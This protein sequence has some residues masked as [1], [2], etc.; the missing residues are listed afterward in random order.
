[1]GIADI[2]AGPVSTLVTDL[3]DRVF[4]DKDKQAAER[5]AFLQKSQ[6]I[7]AQLATA[8]AAIDQAEAANTSVFVAG[9][10]PFIGWVCG[11]ALAYHFIFQPF[12]TYIL[13]NFTNVK[14]VLPEFD[15]SQL[16]TILMG[17]LGLGVLRT[18]ESMGNKGHLPWQQ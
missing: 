7:D 16:T 18:T 3:I 15:M 9:W 8:Q 12:L 5:A 10:R 11:A 13:V 17:M 1:M 14:T 2:I 6:E 4:P